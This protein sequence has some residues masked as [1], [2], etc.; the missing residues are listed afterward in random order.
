[1]N[2]Y[3]LSQILVLI[4][5]IFIAASFF[6][7]KKKDVTILCVLYCIFYSVHYLL[8]GA[9]TGMFMSLISASRNILFYRYA[10]KNMNNKFITLIFFSSFAIIT[11]IYSYQDLFSFISILANI[12]STYSIWQDNI[13]KYRL[14]A[15]PV[16]FCFI[17][18]A[19]HIN[20]IFS[21]VIE[22]ILLIIEII[23]VMGINCNNNF[24]SD[25][26]E[27]I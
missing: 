23:S 20:S 18:Y 3:I 14:Y 11:G 19:V 1:M 27:K 4:S 22:L 2:R 24:R 16:S 13:N 26:Y 25:S 10:K 9:Y 21:L 5:S 17:V 12:L 8:L 15:I 7:K 6:S